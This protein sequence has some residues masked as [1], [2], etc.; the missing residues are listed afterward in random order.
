MKSGCAGEREREREK[1]NEKVR[2]IDIIRWIEREKY[3]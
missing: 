1:V 3:K 2:G